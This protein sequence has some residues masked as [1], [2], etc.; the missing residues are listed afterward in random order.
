MS[1]HLQ[2]TPVIIP[3]ICPTCD[4]ERD[5]T[6]YDVRWCQAHE[7]QRGGVD[8]QSVRTEAY[9]SGNSEAGGYDNA[10]WCELLHRKARLL[11]GGAG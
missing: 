6:T 5:A 7:P 1:D 11:T 2:D 8:D 10:R 4:P 9:L 3:P